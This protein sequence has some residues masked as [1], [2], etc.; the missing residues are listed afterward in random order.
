VEEQDKVVVLTAV[1]VDEIG[2]SPLELAD[3]TWAIPLFSTIG[4]AEAFL[5]TVWEEI[6]PG[7]EAREV[8]PGALRHLLEHV[9]DQ[10]VADHVVLSPSPEGFAT[11]QTMPI[12]VLLEAWSEDEGPEPR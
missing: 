9:A 5:E 1:L 8:S 12:D 10:G 11:V 6:G 7:W 2:L 3:G 4:D